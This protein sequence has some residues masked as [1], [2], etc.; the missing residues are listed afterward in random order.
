M[1]ILLIGSGY[2]GQALLNSWNNPNYSFVVTTTTKSKIKTIQQIQCVEEALLLEIKKN[3]QLDLLKNFDV[4]IM[5]IAPKK[6][7]NYSETYFE[8]A[9]AIQKELSNVKQSIFLIYTS[10]TSVYGPCEGRVVDELTDKSSTSENSQILID[11]EN[12]FL[13]S[14][15]PLAQICILRLGGIYGPGRSLESRAKMMSSRKLS[16][17]GDEL[18][19]HIHISDITAAI[20]FCI[21]HNLNGLYNLVGDEH[22]AR[23]NLYEHICK[24]L[25]IPPPQFDAS[26]KGCKST[27]AAVSNQKIKSCGYIFKE[28]KLP[29]TFAN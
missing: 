13:S 12:I 19:N 2:V 22:P 14:N 5:N 15:N 23:K 4:I 25:S 17:T 24:Q 8:V 27:N 9:S 20:E 6:G 10:S 26:S 28:S 18:T 7:S 1:R 3:T 29:T 21:T 11:T 16:G